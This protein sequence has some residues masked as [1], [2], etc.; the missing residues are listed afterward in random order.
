MVVAPFS[1]PRSPLL[2]PS[3]QHPFTPSRR[4][5]P[6]EGVVCA[7]LPS[8]PSFRKSPGSKFSWECDHGVTDCKYVHF[9]PA[10][11]APVLASVGNARSSVRGGG[12]A[13]EQR[14]P[15]RKTSRRRGFSFLAS[16]GQLCS[17]RGWV[18]EA[19]MGISCLEAVGEAKSE[20]RILYYFRGQPVA[21]A[22]IA[23]SALTCAS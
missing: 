15:G 10:F 22:S 21:G 14:F 23:Q 1:S 7:Y 2:P 12:L 18:W 4:L 13:A 20:A 19:R 5:C 17:C 9:V 11:G 6:G 8:C 3:C 16:Y